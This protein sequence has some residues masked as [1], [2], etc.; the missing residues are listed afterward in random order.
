MDTS[1]RLAAP[2]TL[3]AMEVVLGLD[4]LA[5]IALLS[6]RIDEERRGLAHS[7]RLWLALRFR[8][9][10]LGVVGRAI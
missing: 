1:L 5:F 8:L 6:K 10:L 9:A 7:L 4:N 2:A 3:I